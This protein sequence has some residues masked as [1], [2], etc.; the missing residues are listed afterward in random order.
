MNGREETSQR[1]EE[2]QLVVPGAM[3]SLRTFAIGPAF[4]YM[5]NR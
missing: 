4:G 2:L 3:I 1:L 5:Q